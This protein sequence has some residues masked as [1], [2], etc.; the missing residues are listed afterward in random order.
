[1]ETNSLYCKHSR[2]KDTALKV[3][4]NLAA[5]VTVVVLVGIIGCCFANKLQNICK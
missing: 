5:G 2:P 3:L 4:I 1:M